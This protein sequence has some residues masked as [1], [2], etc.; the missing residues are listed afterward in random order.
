[1]PA[2]SK[3]PLGDVVITSS[4]SS[5]LRFSGEA[6]TAY[7]DRHERGD[8]GEVMPEDW[9]ENDAAVQQGRRILSCYCTA[10]NHHLWIVTEGDR[11]YTRVMVP[12]EF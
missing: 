7:L 5:A 2:H 3:F 12:D 8:W 4:A 6:A 10:M 1:M 11:L 9:V